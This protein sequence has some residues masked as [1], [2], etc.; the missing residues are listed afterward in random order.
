MK[1]LPHRR[2]TIETRLPPS[3]VAARLQAA[4][5]PPQTFRF[6]RPERPLIGRVDGAAFDIIR[7]IRG[8]NSFIPRVRG[9]IEPAGGG[10]RLTGTMQLHEFV[11]VFIGAFFLMAGSVFIRMAVDDLRRGQLGLPTVIALGV[12]V[13]LT[14]MVSIGFVP[15]T[16]RTRAE[17]GRVVDAS[18]GELR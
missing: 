4:V 8:R 9:T 1:L 14:A 18:H 12:L 10:S 3:E 15:E 13:F 11:I 6:S 16:H 5:E 17:L 2:F 7:A